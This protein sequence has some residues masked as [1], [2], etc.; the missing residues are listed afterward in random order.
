MIGDYLVARIAR[1]ARRRGNQA[2]DA[3]R[4]KEA[5]EA[6][7]RVVAARPDDAAIWVQLGHALSETGDYD[8]ADRAYAAAA[9]ASAG[10][11]DLLL[12]WGHSRH[13]AGDDDRAREL[14]RR[15]FAI[16]ANPHAAAALDRSAP[17]EP[18]P[19]GDPEPQPD[20]P[21]FAGAIESCSGPEVTGFVRAPEGPEATFVEFAV[22]DRVVGRAA[23][24]EYRPGDDGYA[25]DIVLDVRGAEQVTARRLPDGLALLYSPFAASGPIPAAPRRAEEWSG[26]V[27]DVWAQEVK[28]PAL[29]QG[30]EIALFVTHSATGALK[31]HVA[32][33]LRALKDEGIAVLL[34]A[35]VD[36]QLAIPPA[37]LDLVAGALVR[38]N[39]GYDFAA[40]GHALRLYPE[41]YGASILYLLNDSVALSADTGRLARVLA[42]VRASGADLIGLT[43]S[44]EY[45]W[46][47]QS[48]FL[49]LKPR[50]LA[51]HAL[52]RFFG[53]VRVLT[54]KDAV[55][56]DYELALAPL[57]E[58]A[59]HRV[60]V[61]FASPVAL[62]PT[63]FGWRGLLGEGFPFV[64]LLLLRGAFP[65]ADI[66]GWREALAAAAFD[67][68]VIDAT[69][70]A[71]V[72]EVPT[73]DGHSLYA[74]P[75]WPAPP[76]DRPL[77]VA[78]Y[79]PWNY[80]NGLGAASRGT[81]AALRR[82]GARL[83][84]HPLKQPFHVHR[85]LAPPVDVAEF[86]GPADVAIVHLNPDS[87]FLLTR[88][89]RRAIREATRRIGYWVW[90]MAHLPE[91][92]WHEFGA[93]DRIWAPSHYCADLFERQ[94]GAPVDVIPHAVPLL[95][96]AAIDRPALLGALG[97]A[98]DRRIVLFVFDG[99]SYLVRKNPGALV[100]AFAASGLAARGW[101]LVLKT[102]HLMDRPEEG[103]ALRALAQATAGV[104][105]IDRAASEDELRALGALAD[106]YAS[107]HCSEGFGLTL[108]EAMAAGTPVVATDFGGSRDFLDAASGYPVVAARWRLEEDFGHYTQGGEWARIDETALA[109]A[110]AEAARAVEAGDDRKGRAGRARI[111]AA[112]SYERVGALIDASLR[113]T[114]ATPPPAPAIRP[115][116]PDLARG[117]PFEQAE[118]GPLIRAVALADDGAARADAIELGEHEWIAFAPGASIA[119]PDFADLVAE[120]AR[121]RPDA[122]IFYGDDLA[123]ET[124]QP[125]D[126]LRLKPE[127]DRT[128]L[129]A[130]DY[131]GAPVIVRAAA[132]RELDGLRPDR[133][134]AAIADLLFRAHAAGLSIARIPEVLLAHPNARVRATPD[135]YRAMLEAQPALAAC[136]V[137]PGRA[138]ASFA[139][140]RR[141]AP[142]TEPPVTILVPTCRT[143]L[144]DGGGSYV[145]RLLDRLGETDWPMERLRVIVGD[146]LAG[147]PAWASARRPFALERIETPRGPAE[148]FNYAAKMNRL[149]R[150]AEDEQIVFL[151]D[152]VLPSEP[153]W[154]RALQTFAL[155]G[156][157]GGVGARLL[158]ADGRLQH[159]G[160]G[161]QRLA[162][163]HLWLRR[164]RVEGTYQDWA[165]VQREWSV[166]TGAVFATRR[167]LM[168]Q[169]A[170]FDE[171]FSVEFNDVDLCLRLR[172]LG[173]RIVCAPRAEMVHAEKASR[174]DTLPP[175][176]DLAR[177]LARWG[178]WLAHDPAWHPGLDRTRLDMAPLPDEGAWYR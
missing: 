87:L 15:S 141:F 85:P 6:Y 167:S 73:E 10:D 16:D 128:L 152:D 37:T 61:L 169:V 1:A 119:A 123:A 53:T 172:M 135:D 110:L 122:A 168:E 44:H 35:V 18:A 124:A 8:E 22:D 71:G 177:F 3:R 140:A 33:Y 125:I 66:A 102:K 107:P 54:D 89:Q 93:V 20:E 77:K 109:A 159:A 148:P 162:T 101:S 108:A 153:G 113:D 41:A 154:L 150:A 63:L 116:R 95:P 114:L 106:I 5:I 17:D 166:V 178:P 99:S 31:P 38:A 19:A 175:G 24:K 163:A 34:I 94:D 39:E 161:P 104:V 126:Q 170:G 13:A 127:F 86:A 97:L 69:L 136:E 32:P 100:R 72:E 60:E 160:L 52:H 156:G 121:R 130:Q 112:L 129:A 65:E 49:A 118:F 46:H 23:L 117:V 132:L 7:R 12:C 83:N 96:P 176:E 80:D 4:W 105:L 115:F 36:R 158:Y 51:A 165:L 88:E 98:A 48:Y 9:R 43:E 131:V 70:A 67:L 133:G 145:E 40:W 79:G 84:L 28:P 76:G 55:I 92:W 57:V 62:N 151:N 90:E 74:H 47:V 157:V 56:R 27:A 11:A 134:T 75:V 26:P 171:L 164:R 137:L 103:G 42:R 21:V 146:D 139:L 111:A 91:S 50:L 143:A 149:W 155:D 173:Y 45:R 2:R 142:G 120:H 147:A 144:P 138:P 82:S 58:Q 59:G 29:A 81:I 78:F 174:G 30:S 14:Y 64:K 68:A 25:F